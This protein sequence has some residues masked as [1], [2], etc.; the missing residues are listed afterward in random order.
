MSLSFSNFV[1]L[2][3]G[4]CV[5]GGRMLSDSA[6]N[7][8][9]A[10]DLRNNSTTL[11]LTVLSFSGLPQL[12]QRK[13]A[14]GTP[15]TRCREMHQSGRVTIMLE[16]RSSPHDGS[17]FTFLISSSVR[18]RRVSSFPVPPGIGVS[19]EMNHCSVAR[20]MTGLWQRQQCGYE[21]SIFSEA[22]RTWRAFSSSTMSALASKTRLP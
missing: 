22:I 5:P 19:M 2:Q 16:S 10:P 4:H 3:C 1:P 18:P 9:S 14:M 6:E 21:C 13:T 7:Q 12:S 20:K 17:H 15:H 11:W 8:E